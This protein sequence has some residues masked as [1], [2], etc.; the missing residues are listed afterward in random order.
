MVRPPLA[1]LA[2][3]P[4]WAALGTR[5]LAFPATASSAREAHLIG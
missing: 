2:G 3:T 5:L 1:V 4:N